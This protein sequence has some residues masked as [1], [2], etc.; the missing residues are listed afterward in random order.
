MKAI[1]SHPDVEAAGL[2]SESESQA[3]A[4]TAELED[5]E[6]AVAQEVLSEE[7]CFSL[8]QSESKQQARIGDIEYCKQFYAVNL[9]A[10]KTAHQN[11]AIK[12]VQAELQPVFSVYNNGRFINAEHF[13][14]LWV[15]HLPE[16]NQALGDSQLLNPLIID[17][18]LDAQGRF[19]DMDY[20]I[21]VNAEEIHP[22]TKLKMNLSVE[23]F[24]YGQ[25][26][27]ID[28]QQLREAQP[29]KDAFKNS[30]LAQL[31]NPSKKANS[32]DA[33]SMTWDEQLAQLA[34]QVYANTG[35]Y[36]K[37]YKA[38]FIAK[39][40]AEQPEF[41]QYYSAQDLQEIAAVYA[42]RF[43]DEDSYSLK[44]TSLKKN[45]ALQ[46]KHHLMLEAEN[47]FDEALGT[48]VDELVTTVIAAEQPQYDIQ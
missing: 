26:T 14:Q 22:S 6:H 47:V 18:V 10:H 41:V 36:E 45:E 5:E 1:E 21:Q 44:D 7:Q 15:T 20:D 38:V 37:T 43:S 40:T 9:L 46:K 23:L 11:K 29:F 8:V 35:S 4:T 24:N 19:I 28:R 30:M 27:T 2:T 25:A 3:Q 31:L 39:L 42:Y 17:V 32:Q 33:S 12:D 34:E 48:G 13:K 16:I